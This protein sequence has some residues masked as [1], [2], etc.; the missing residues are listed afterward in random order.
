M[1]IKIHSAIDLITNSSTEIFTYSGSSPTALKEMIEELFKT[2]EIHKTFDEV[3][4]AV[5]LCEHI[6]HYKDFIRDNDELPEG[7]IKETDIDA[8]I[9]DVILGKVEKPQWFSDVEAMEL[10]CDYF[11]PDTIL[12]LT[13]KLPEYEKLASLVTKFLYSTDHEA[14]YNG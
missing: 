4:H 13:P 2:F 8:L 10:Q 12:Y 1:K 6:Y 9:R 3:F 14:T 11:Q 5:V 7:I